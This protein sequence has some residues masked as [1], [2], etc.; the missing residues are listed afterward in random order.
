ML[1]RRVALMLFALGLFACTLPAMG[2]NRADPAISAIIRFRFMTRI[3]QP[4]RGSKP[5]TRVIHA[6]HWTSAEPPL[7]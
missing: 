7:A 4:C 3:L 2:S 6:T 1:T 5:A